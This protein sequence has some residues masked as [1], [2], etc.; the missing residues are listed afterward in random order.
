VTSPRA[1]GES[2]KRHREVRGISLKAVAE[3]TKISPT[4]LT[5]LERGDCSKWPG[6]IYSRAWLRAYAKAIGQDPEEVASEFTRCFVHTAFPNGEPVPPPPKPIGIP[7][8]SPFRL[9]LEPDPRE[10]TRLIHRRLAFLAA[11]ILIAVAIA[12]T[13]SK[14]GLFEFWTV[15]AAG[16][17]TCHA[18]GLIGG[19]GSAAGWVQRRLR[20][21]AR[22]VEGEEAVAEAA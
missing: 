21:H 5:A 11:D 7:K 8:V 20:R 3:K 10:R 15:F 17:V 12:V 9:T 16:A 14:L 19:G 13:L 1:F 4:F 6:G 2:L 18:V 22:P